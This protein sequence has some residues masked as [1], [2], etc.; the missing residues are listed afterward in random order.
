[1]NIS[2]PAPYTSTEA[3][4]LFRLL[5][6]YGFINGSFD[7]ISHEL[8]NTPLILEQEEYDAGRLTSDKLQQ[9]A[10]ELVRDEQRRETEAAAETGANGHSPAAKKRKLQPPPLPTLKEAHER[11]EKLPILVDRLNARFREELIRQIQEDEQEYARIEEECDEIERGEWDEKIRAEKEKQLAAAGSKNVHITDARLPPPRANGNGIPIPVPAATQPPQPPPRAPDSGKRVDTSISTPIPTPPQTQT[12]QVVPEKRPVQ[13]TPSPIAP[14]PAPRP[15]AE[16][17]HSTPDAL[18]NPNGTTPVLQHPPVG[19][20]IAQR[21]P[22][23]TPQPHVP[24]ALQR[25]DI[26]SKARSPGP[27]QQ[28]Q[29]GTQGPGQA[30]ALKWEP[31]YIPHPQAHQQPQQQPYHQQPHQQLHPQPH[32]TA[33]PPPRPPYGPTNPPKPASG[34]PSNVQ[35]VPGASQRPHNV[36]PHISNKQT[37]GQTPSPRPPQTPVL[38]PPQHAG[39]I[40][41]SL[42]N[43]PAHATPDSAGQQNTQNRTPSVPPVAP[44]GPSIPPSMHTQHLPPSI[45]KQ[46]PMR[47]PTGPPVSHPQTVGTPTKPPTPAAQRAP[48]VASTRT[49]HPQPQP[50][51]HPQSRPPQPPLP[52]TPA[53]LPQKGPTLVLGTPWNQQGA[54]NGS[55][56]APGPQQAPIQPSVTTPQVPRPVAGLQLQT[57]SGSNIRSHVIRGHGTKWTSTPTPATPRMEDVSSYFDTQS[58]AFEPISPPLRPAQL[59][60]STPSSTSKSEAGQGGGKVEAS[61]PRGRPSRAHKI[62]VAQQPEDEPAA[63]AELP[64]PHIKHEA[65]T[66]QA[67]EETG[68]SSFDGSTTSRVPAGTSHLGAKR[69]RQ[70]SPLNREPPTPA[71]H[72]LWTRAFHKISMTALD[73][74]IGHR[75]ANMFAHPIKPKLAPGYYDIILRPTDLKNIQ[76]A[77]TMGSKAAAAAV[78]NM[79]DVDPNATSVWLPISIDLVPPR[80]IINIAQLERE[81]IHMF[82]N[83][84]M[85]NPDPLR[86]LGPS[87]L[88]S[89]RSDGDGEGDD[90]RGYEFDE[91]GVVKETRNM[92][93]EVEK[94]LGDLRNEVVPRTHA[95]NGSRSVSAAVGESNTVEE[96]GDEQGGDAKRR[97]I[98]G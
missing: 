66:P 80:G 90:A 59:P 13:P 8:L 79:P 21:P 7:R 50:R 33:V 82:A 29:V 1:M 85:Y 32:Q 53:Q 4:F 19:Q 6:K 42:H 72:V 81:L 77:I 58:P 24:D 78:A 25:P 84:I 93:A 61:R 30:T 92:Y 62:E 35:S 87:F 36:Q 57:P 45:P 75:Y 2:I 9:L 52:A 34:S 17:R 97:R 69:K 5:N 39:Q 91:N 55:H 10:L 18:R 37:P 16:Q 41:P 74:I 27:A 48:A 89:Y 44:T 38:L 47:V 86:G 65:A 64:P 3:L 49:P 54:T 83:A 73:Q 94:L 95:G 43:P 56:P 40:P 70:D 23:V 71:T 60:E 26:V 67:F 63:D 11:R 96:D 12:P 14:A 76:K 15:K 20:G 46:T 68:E 28:G 98:R 22:T 88:K 51:P 31:P